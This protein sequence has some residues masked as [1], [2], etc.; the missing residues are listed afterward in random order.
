MNAFEIAEITA[1][2]MGNFLTSFSVFLSVASA[3]LVAAYLV[4]AKLTT[5]QLSIV[6]GSYLIATS[7]LGYLVGA[8]YRV[9]YIWASSNSEGVVRQ[10]EN[11][12]ALIDFSWPISILLLIIV[13]GSLAFMYSIRTG[14]SDDNGT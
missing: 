3:Y 1:S 6:N 11:R 4:G 8:N 9:F 5:F 12:P 13:I 7:I 10:S 14:G 2:S